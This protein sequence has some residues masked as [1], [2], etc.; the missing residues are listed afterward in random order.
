MAA[1]TEEF[2]EDVKNRDSEKVEVKVDEL[3]SQKEVNIPGSSSPSPQ[4]GK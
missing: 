4:V 1:F 3:S 2:E